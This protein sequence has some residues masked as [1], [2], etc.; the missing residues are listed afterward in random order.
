MLFLYGEGFILF[1]FFLEQMKNAGTCSYSVVITTSCSSPRYTRDQISISFGDAYGNQVLLSLH[2]ISP[3]V[4][5]VFS[6]RAGQNC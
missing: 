3:F 4:Y 6:E 5:C 2:S 1:Y